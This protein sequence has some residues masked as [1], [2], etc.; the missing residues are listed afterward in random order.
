MIRS[1]GQV[2]RTLS[3]GVYIMQLLI[4]FVGFLLGAMFPN[5]K[6]FYLAH[7]LSPIKYPG[8]EI[9][10]PEVWR[11]NLEALGVLVSA[12]FYLERNEFEG[13]DPNN[14][15]KVFRK[16]FGAVSRSKYF[17]ADL[18]YPSAGVVM[19]ILLFSLLA[20]LFPWSG[21]KGTI[22]SQESV[23]LSSMVRGLIFF[24]ESVWR[25]EYYAEE[26]ERQLKILNFFSS[27]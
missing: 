4:Q 25:I 18:S 20:A 26:D 13:Y 10:V 12:Q 5:G 1:I 22:L 16:D 2:L 27:R 11:D 21:R 23:Y 19:E 15:E 7:S 3:F 8:G 17:V 24:L 9:P 6:S 14:P